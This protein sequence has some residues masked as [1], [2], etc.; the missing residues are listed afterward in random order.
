[1]HRR[2]RTLYVMIQSKIM[3]TLAVHRSRIDN[4]GNEY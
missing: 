3:V 4:D 2:H 1:M